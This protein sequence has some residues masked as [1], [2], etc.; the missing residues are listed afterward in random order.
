MSTALS[1]RNALAAGSEQDQKLFPKADP[2]PPSLN[3][4]V[5]C[6]HEQ[7]GNQ[8]TRHHAKAIVTV[9]LDMVRLLVLERRPC[10]LFCPAVGA[11]ADAQGSGWNLSTADQRNGSRC[12]HKPVYLRPNQP[13]D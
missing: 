8:E 6:S 3:S 9:L 1:S 10:L 12:D 2:T 4:F 7:D 13:S 5:L 11:I